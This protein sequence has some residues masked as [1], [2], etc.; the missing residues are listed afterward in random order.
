M[1]VK[2]LIAILSQYDLETKVKIDY[3]GTIMDIQQIYEDEDFIF[4]G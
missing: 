4:I 1:T 3:G 2:E